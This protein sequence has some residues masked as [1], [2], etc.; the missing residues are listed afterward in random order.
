MVERG[1]YD[2]LAGLDG[3]FKAMIDRQ[4]SGQLAPLDCV[5]PDVVVTVADGRADLRLTFYMG[6][7]GFG[8]AEEAMIALANG[9]RERG[10]DVDMVVERTG[11]L[12][13]RLDPS[14][15]V[16]VLAPTG[17]PSRVARLARHIRSRNPDVIVVTSYSLVLPATMRPKP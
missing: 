6:S 11:P 15:S 8:G 16:A 9:A 14:I 3:E 13:K 17:L 7:F 1:T 12:Q 5:R 4:S 2:E 10:Y